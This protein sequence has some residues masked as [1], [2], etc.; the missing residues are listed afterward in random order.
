MPGRTIAGCQPCPQ[1]PKQREKAE[2]WPA[3]SSGRRLHTLLPAATLL[4]F[5]VI[6]LL[7]W[8]H[9][10]RHDRELVQRYVETSV[11]QVRIRIEG[12]MNARLASL[13]LMAERWV[14]RKPPNFSRQR[15]QNF[16]QALYKNYP[17]YA[18][19]CWIDPAGTV[20]WVFPESAHIPAV[21]QGLAGNLPRP[22]LDDGHGNEVVITP[23]VFSRQGRSY[24]H[25]VRV[26]RY[27]HR[28]QGYLGGFFSVDQLMALCLTKELRNDFL[29]D[30]AEAGRTIYRHGYPGRPGAEGPAADAADAPGAVS[31]VRFGE[32][33][34][35]VALTLN[36]RAYR[37]DLKKNFGLLA[38][39]LLLAAG[40]SLLLHLLMRRMILYKASRDQAMLEVRE[41]QQT[42]AALRENEK[43]L[44]ALLAEL[45]AKNAELESFVYTVSHDLK[46]PI[47]TIEGFIGAFR[48]DFGDQLTETSAQYL[49]YMSDATCKMELLI[50][51]L[52]NYSRI[53]RL[54]EE[55]TTFAMH[56]PLADALA[57][58][59]PQIESRGIGLTLPAD[60]PPVCASRK[61]IEQVWLNLLSNAVKYVGADN[62]RPQ[63]EIGCTP[64]DGKP[65]F[66][67]R[68]N[69]IGIDSKYF[70][71]IFQIFERLPAA[72]RA[73]E[74][75]GIGLAIVKRIVEHHGGRIWLD[76][77]PGAG[78][79]FYF[80]VENEE[81]A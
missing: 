75:T 66:W 24:F 11:E 15:F 45:T 23:C 41:R 51:E 76:S 70:D 57:T 55:R 6:A 1:D 65:V 5:G 64:G 10:N 67:V 50:N 58:L 2:V 54:Q 44:Q 18:A 7:L 56:E 20:Q 77:V 28:L 73:G 14:E 29:V 38:F 72:K 46:T 80:T 61:R 79:T 34:W 33:G 9:Q 12:L 49:R 69:G 31:E 32:K 8:E 63:I 19:I 53:G 17:G 27:D 47:V 36:R 71:K 22:D 78:T 42:Q 21:D 37:S 62:A 4:L 40:L 74:G 52:L 13:E 59:R 81:G 3:I 39:G 48:E 43:E 26:M 68:D 30:V 60:L 25:A 16:A 35:Q